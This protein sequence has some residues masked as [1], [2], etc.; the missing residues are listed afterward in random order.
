MYGVL[1]STTM[2]QNHFLYLKF[3]WWTTGSNHSTVYHSAFEK[4]GTNTYSRIMTRSLHFSGFNLLIITIII[5]YF[6]GYLIDLYDLMSN[7]AITKQHYAVN[8]DL[9]FL[10]KLPSKEGKMIFT[11]KTKYNSYAIT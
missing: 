3:K 1:F 10:F 2:T 7:I 6:T 9:A 11:S 8:N 4:V 5:F